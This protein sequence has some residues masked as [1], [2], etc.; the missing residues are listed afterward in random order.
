MTV[1]VV[2]PQLGQ[3]MVTGLVV[4]WHI[5]DGETVQA[6]APLLTVES[7]KS[8]FELEASASGIVRHFANEGAEIDVGAR[9]ATI[10]AVEGLSAPEAAPTVAPKPL[11]PAVAP[12]AAKGEARASPRARALAEGRIALADII[13]TGTD[14]MITAA[15]V[16]KALTIRT[17]AQPSSAE[18]IRRKIGAGHRSAIR[19]L[20]ASWNQAPHIVQMI[21]VDATH[22]AAAQRAQRAGMLAATL[23]DIVIHAAARTM[24]EFPDINVRID[25]D[26]IV[27]SEQVDVSI[28]VAT[29]RGLRTPV[30]T[31]IG[32]ATLDEIAAAGR[33]AIQASREGRA[34][35]A[36]ASLTVSNLG[37]Y[38]V[39]FGSPV[40]NLDE[41]VLVFV[42]AIEDRAVV[43]D[44][45][46]AVRPGLTLSIAYD[47]RAV[48]GLR[49]AEFSSTLR[50][51][52]ETLDL[53]EPTSTAI[54]PER[55]VRLTATSGLRCDLTNGRHSWVIDEPPAIGGQDKGPD[56]VTSVLAAL[57]SCMTIAFRLVANRRKVSIERVTGSIEAT[58]EGKVQEIRAVLEV[59][60][61][62]P[63]KRVEALLKPAKAACY[64]HDM[65]RP[66]LPLDIALRVHPAQ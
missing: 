38:G 54:H 16:E 2:M 20:Q 25:G 57:L 61:H 53:P 39:R 26:E 11:N 18:G 31:D 9:L 62:E 43:V 1:E 28:A 59:W 50:R 27:Q 56:P 47:H 35:A 21:E 40:L 60:S 8:A 44:G 7:D 52:L 41:T 58:A 46:V 55:A 3:A 14:G 12:S 66:D 24:S 5:A 36:R 42:G 22:L 4:T 34:A 63:A 37:R 6:G 15:D 51:K 32:S 64:V 33:T 48:D 49:A 19:R 30:L 10:G 65:L 23:N 17:N 29:D 13:A 45:A